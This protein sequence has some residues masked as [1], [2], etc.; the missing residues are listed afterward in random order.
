MAAAVPGV[1]LALGRWLGAP[2]GGADS[3][4]LASPPL[5]WVSGVLTKLSTFD[6]GG[7]VVPVTAAPGPELFE[8]NV[9][10]AAIIT[11]SMQP[12]STAFTAAGPLPCLR[13]L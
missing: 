11:S 10:P 1:M 9:E 12:S 5:G 6:D 7:A 4:V 3:G 2:D 8:K 13:R